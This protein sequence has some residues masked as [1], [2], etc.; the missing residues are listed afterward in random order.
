MAHFRC[1]THLIHPRRVQDKADLHL[2]GE[3]LVE[4][5]RD[6]RRVIDEFRAVVFVHPESEPHND[7]SEDGH[8]KAPQRGRDGRVHA[9]VYFSE[10]LEPQEIETGLSE[11]DHP[12]LS[13]H[14]GI[15][16]DPLGQRFFSLIAITDREAQGLD[17]EIRFEPI[18][19]LL[20]VQ[21]VQVSHHPMSGQNS[22]SRM[23]QGREVHHHVFVGSVGISVPCCP[24]FLLV[25][26]GGFVPV[27]AVRDEDAL[28]HERR[29]DGGYCL[30]IFKGPGA[31][32]GPVRVSDFL[33]R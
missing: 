28:I 7:L 6:H 27:M 23:R 3:N 1:C 21:T 17:L 16:P 18:K 14:L 31:V 24:H 10:V 19:G 22:E 4:R 32:D 15:R 33:L 9:R 13:T 11:G 29:P 20:E 25:R 2:S 12:E 26:D 5:F 30:R 8:V